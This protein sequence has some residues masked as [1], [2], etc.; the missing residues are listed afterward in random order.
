M[1]VCVLLRHRNCHTHTHTLGAN[2]G[3]KELEW[4]NKGKGAAGQRPWPRKKGMNLESLRAKRHWNDGK[5]HITKELITKDGAGEVALVVLLHFIEDEK[6]TASLKTVEYAWIT[7]CSLQW[8]R[9]IDRGMDASEVT[10]VDS[11]Y[12]WE[13]RLTC[14]KWGIFSCTTG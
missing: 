14:R 7:E 12:K 3:E 9:S 4:L 13:L 11:S 1:C 5:K 10:W 6:R 2:K 8:R